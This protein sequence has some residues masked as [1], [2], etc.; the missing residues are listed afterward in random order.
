MFLLLLFTI[1]ASTFAAREDIRF[2]A[3]GFTDAEQL[4]CALKVDSTTD[5]FR[6]TEL[7]LLTQDKGGSPFYPAVATFSSS[8]DSMSITRLGSLEFPVL[9][10]SGTVMDPVMQFGTAINDKKQLVVYN[11]TSGTKIKEIDI[12]NAGN[13]G[14]LAIDMTTHKIYGQY[15]DGSAE[16]FVEVDY[17]NGKVTTIGTINL[18][19][20]MSA[21]SAID[22][23]KK[24]FYCIASS[25][26]SGNGDLLGIDLA[27]GEEKIRKTLSNSIGNG[28]LF[29]DSATD[30][31]KA[32]CRPYELIDKTNR[33]TDFSVCS[34]DPTTGI[35][36]VVA[37]DADRIPGMIMGKNAFSAANQLYFMPGTSNSLDVYDVGSGK[38]VKNLPRGTKEGLIFAMTNKPKCEC[39]VL[40]AEEDSKKK[41]VNGRRRLG[42]DSCTR[43]TKDTSSATGT[44]SLASFAALLSVTV[45]VALLLV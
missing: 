39:C 27:T 37:D 9:S 21:T 1:C 41:V 23:K 18:Q 20:K 31:L 30:T 22:Y 14:N 36:S 17:N 19:M 8:G 4:Q 40:A 42:Y 25:M 15:W 10:T 6:G 38:L 11:T 44:R 24:L 32:F 45:V 5:V 3:S 29:F 35:A 16:Q 13:L 34:I 2:V 43:K 33:K 26:G 28:G 12:S 7:L